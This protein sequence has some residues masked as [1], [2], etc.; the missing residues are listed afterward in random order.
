MNKFVFTSESA[1]NGHPDKTC[2]IISY[3]VLDGYLEKGPYAK[4]AVETALKNNTVIL[5]G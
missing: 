3:S 1:A 5:L 2:D 4:V